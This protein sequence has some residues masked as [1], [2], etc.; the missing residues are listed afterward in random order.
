[1]ELGS[2]EHGDLGLEVCLFSSQGF[3]SRGELDSEEV[4]RG[5]EELEDGRIAFDHGEDR[6]IR[7]EGE[8]GAAF[9]KYA[10]WQEVAGL[11]EEEGLELLYKTEIAMLHHLLVQPWITCYLLGR[12]R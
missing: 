6:T 1:M 2:E 9:G 5:G 8:V 7:R 4:R 12:R 11:R 3:C 10:E